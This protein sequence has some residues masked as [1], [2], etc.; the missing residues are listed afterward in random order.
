MVIANAT[1]CS[2]IYGGS[3]PTCPYT[4]N[5]EGNGPAWANS[6]F[7]DN[8]E[9]G[10]G[11]S[12]AFE[13][14]RNVLADILKKLANEAISQELKDAINRWLEVKDDGSLSKNASKTLEAAVKSEKKVS[15]G[16]LKTLLGTIEKASDLF[17]KKS[18]WI[19]GGDGWAYDI[20]YN[21]VD[22]V[23]ASGDDVNILVLDTEVYSNTGG[24]ASKSTPTGATAKFAA[25]GKR[26]KKK[27]L[28]SLAM[29][30]GNVYVAQ[31]SMGA[32]M[33]QVVKA[34]AEAEA[35]KGTSIIIAYAPCISH[36]INMS[37]SQLEMKKAVD[38]GYWQLFRYN[39]DLLGTDKSPLTIDSKDPISDYS[40]FL[41]GENR[42]AS[43]AKQNPETAKILFAE[44]EA[45]ATKKREFYK[46]KAEM[47]KSA[48]KVE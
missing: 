28:A 23:L 8:A 37:K 31:V 35:Y 33:N 1:G 7:E 26:T 10:Y 16:S 46:K 13:Q 2:S 38:S 3:A 40:E 27:D 43:L 34:F 12:I 44:N 18:I 36:G 6:L 19:I 29:D 24:Q 45:E 39:P 9:F 48:Q 22:H 20:G 14:R 42:Y 30:Y 41:M 25:T 21:G 32:D 5:D 15:K 11:M 47:L 4:T 17:V